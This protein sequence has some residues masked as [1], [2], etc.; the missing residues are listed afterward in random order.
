MSKQF[1]LTPAEGYR[2]VFAALEVATF[3]SPSVYQRCKR[4]RAKGEACSYPTIGMDKYLDLIDAL[5]DISP[6]LFDAT[7]KLRHG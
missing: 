2:L 4:A 7:I 3:P 5:E 6:G 1:T